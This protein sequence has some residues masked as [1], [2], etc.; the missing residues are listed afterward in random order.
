MHTKHCSYSVYSTVLTKAEAFG[1]SDE[2]EP[3]Y[4][5]IARDAIRKTCCDIMYLIIMSG[6][7]Q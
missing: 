1:V 5:C 6:I 2:E 3:W 4:A 7:G